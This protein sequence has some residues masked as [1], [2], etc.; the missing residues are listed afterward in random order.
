MERKLR[1]EEYTGRGICLEMNHCRQAGNRHAIVWGLSVTVPS[2]SPLTVVA[3]LPA[4]VYQL[5]IGLQSSRALLC[6]Q[7]H[8][9]WGPVSSSKGSANP[10]VHRT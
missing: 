7:L 3:E 1:R 4:Q 6:L 9:P 8:L 5:L 10:S 2:S